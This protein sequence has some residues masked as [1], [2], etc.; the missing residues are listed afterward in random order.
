MKIS[1]FIR[2][3]CLETWRTKKILIIGLIFLCFGILSPL[4]AKLTPELLKLSLHSTLGLPAPTSLDS[5]LQFYKNISQMGL[6]LF[7]IVFSGAMSHELKQG[8]LVN[9]VTKGLARK[10]VLLSKAIV[11]YGQWVLGCW[12]AFGVTYGYTAYYF[13]DHKSA[14]V[15]LAFWPVLIFGLFLVSVLLFFST[16][17]SNQYSGL[18]GT[19]LVMLLLNLIN[20]FETVQRYNPISLVSKNLNIVKQ[21]SQFYDLWPSMGLVL[22]STV[23]LGIVTIKI[24]DRKRL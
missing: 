14:H 1:Y 18:L 15:W 4:S 8:T 3:E 12:L 6:Y 5:W 20:L 23:L 16:L 13:P 22:I 21:S 11:L 10:T 24:F 2:K 17:T 9:L 19:V 7:A